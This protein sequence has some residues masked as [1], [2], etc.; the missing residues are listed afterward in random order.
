MDDAYYNANDMFYRILES[1]GDDA[2]SLERAVYWVVASVHAMGV[3]DPQKIHTHVVMVF[4]DLITVEDHNNIHE[5]VDRA[6][7]ALGVI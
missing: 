1:A 2:S 5:A 4:G 7:V 6:L 3:T